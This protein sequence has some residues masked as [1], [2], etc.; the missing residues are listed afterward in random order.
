MDNFIL[1]ATC[2]A[3]TGIVA[4][5]SGFLVERDCYICGLEQFDDEST[6]IFFM[7]VVFRREEKSSKAVFHD[8]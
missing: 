5:V 6:S 3:T 7:R 8:I 4:A 1:T 2:H